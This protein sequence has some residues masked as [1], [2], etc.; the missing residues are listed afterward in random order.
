MRTSAKLP[1]RTRTNAHKVRLALCKIIMAEDICNIRISSC[2]MHF[3]GVTEQ[4]CKVTCQRLKKFLECRSK[5][6]K[7]DCQQT[8]IAKKSYENVD[9]G[10]VTSYMEKNPDSINLEWY[11]HMKCWK[12]F[13]DEEKICRQQRKEEKGEG[14][15]SKGPTSTEVSPV[16][17][18]P[19]EPRRKIT[20]Q[21]VAEAKIKTLPQTNAHVLPEICIICGRDASWFSLDK[22]WAL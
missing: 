15:S 21:S 12:R 19:I 9:D 18:E 14:T 5:W 2:F 22:V 4:L 17:V 10:S 1:L 8:E 13:C 20:R 7:L 6:A 11:H 16:E 3:D